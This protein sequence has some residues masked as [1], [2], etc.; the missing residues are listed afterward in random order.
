V[1][2]EPELP[3]LR[4]SW[5]AARDGF[6]DQYQLDHTV[7]VEASVAGHDQ[8]YSGWTALPDGRLF[9]V[10]YTDDTAPPVQPGV[11][12]VNARMGISWLRG[13]YLSPADLP[14]ATR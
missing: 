4:I 2:Q 7:E 12:G 11:G 3:L 14:A 1:I 5:D 8:G 10:N 9:V 6:P 13:T